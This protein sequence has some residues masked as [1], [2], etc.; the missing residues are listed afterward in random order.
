MKKELLKKLIKGL[1]VRK[2]KRGYPLD[3]KCCACDCQIK[4]RIHRSEKTADSEII[5]YKSDY[6]NKGFSSYCMEP[7]STAIRVNNLYYCEK[8]ISSRADIERCPICLEGGCNGK[9]ITFTKC[10]HA[11]H[12]ECLSNWIKKSNETKQVFEAICPLCR[13]EL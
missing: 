7:I 12:L 3:C 8:C 4:G 10:N 5:I 13:K 1:M 9:A 11:F 2:Y 6:E